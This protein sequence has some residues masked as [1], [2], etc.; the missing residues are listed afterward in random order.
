MAYYHEAVNICSNYAPAFY[1]IAVVYSETGHAEVGFRDLG[2]GIATGS[3][4]PNDCSVFSTVRA[5]TR[6]QVTVS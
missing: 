1:N 2:K 3:A 5:R 4:L 6:I